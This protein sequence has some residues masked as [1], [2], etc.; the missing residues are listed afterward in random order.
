MPASCMLLL[1]TEMFLCSTFVSNVK[2]L[3]A[4]GT[5]SGEEETVSFFTSLT[6]RL[7]SSEERRC[8][9]DLVV[10]LESG[11]L[12][13]DRELALETDLFFNFFSVDFLSES[14]LPSSPLCVLVEASE[15]VV[16]SLCLLSR[17]MNGYRF[18]TQNESQ[19]NAHVHVCPHKGICISIY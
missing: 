5:G 1:L 6:R 7:V 3:G 14:L 2:T 16:P 9:F 15:A 19:D 13:R 4:R 11:D 17:A 10:S 18:K 12:E 8:F